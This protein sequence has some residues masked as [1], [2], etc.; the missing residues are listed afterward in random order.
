MGKVFVVIAAFN[1]E[2]KIAEVVRDL[3]KE[4]YEKV[5]VVDDGSTDRTA[6][7]AKKLK[8]T[9]LQHSVNRGQG[10]ALK[11]GI[12]YALEQGAEYIVTFD[13][14]GQHDPK[15]IQKLLEPVQSGKVQIA[16]G[17]RFLNKTSQVPFFKKLV[18]KGG[19]LFTLLF[20]GIRL[21]DV[22]NGLRVLSR[23]AAEN[24]EIR[25]DR[26]EHA[27]EIIEEIHKKQIPFM[28]VPVHIRY[29]EYSKQHGQ[30][31]W[32]SVKIAGNLLWRKLTK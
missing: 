21:S 31:P 6:A 27:S 14:D 15:D 11:T 9:V 24:I 10:A 3:R 2:T 1:E 25:Q 32:N 7:R 29:T 16:L 22:H 20:S 17:S 28:E 19:I 30:S 18:L 23:K 12:T 5:V 8:A 26:M 13:A 4:G